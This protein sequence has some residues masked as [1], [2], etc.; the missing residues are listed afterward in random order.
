MAEEAQ[1][2][3]AN[4]KIMMLTRRLQR[5]CER[6]Q[7]RVMEEKRERSEEEDN[8]DKKVERRKV[9]MQLSFKGRKY[10]WKKEFG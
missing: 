7:R 3:N 4:W 2:S 9:V 10:M 5:R 1:E 6:L 8:T